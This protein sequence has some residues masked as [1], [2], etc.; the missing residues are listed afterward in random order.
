MKHV[1]SLILTLI[2]FPSITTAA[3]RLVLQTGHFAPVTTIAF[4]PDGSALASAGEDA[5]VRLWDVRTRELRDILGRHADQV[6]R[7]AF[8]PKGDVLAAVTAG[9][10]VFL[11]NW[12]TGEKLRDVPAHQGPAYAAAFSPDGKVLATGGK[13]GAIHLWD[14]RK[15]T[16]R[17]APKLPAAISKAGI[18]ALAFSPDGKKLAVGFSRAWVSSDDDVYDYEGKKVGAGTIALIDTQTNRV[19][20][21]LRTGRGEQIN[22]LVYSPDGRQLLTALGNRRAEI[23]PLAESAPPKILQSHVLQVTGAAF[24]PD[25]KTVITGSDDA[26]V[27]IWDAV[28]GKGRN[29]FTV[30]QGQGYCVAISPDGK[31]LATG[32]DDKDVRLWEIAGGKVQTVWRGDMN[33][34][35]GLVLPSDSPTAVASY[36]S[37]LAIAAN[38]DDHPELSAIRQWDLR[39]GKLMQVIAIPDYMPELQATTRDGRYLYGSTLDKWDLLRVA[40]AQDIPKRGNDGAHMPYESLALSPDETRLAML[41]HDVTLSVRSIDDGKVM[42]KVPGADDLSTDDLVVKFSPDGKTLSCLLDRRVATSGKAPASTSPIKNHLEIYNTA[43]GQL[44]FAH[45]LQA[46]RALAIA[47]SPD[48]EAVAVGDREGTLRLFGTEYPHNSKTIRVTN[49]EIND[50]DYSPDGRTISC[51]ADDGKIHIIE[52]ATGKELRAL[53]GHEMWTTNVRYLAGGKTIISGGTDMTLRLWRVSDGQLLVTLQILPASKYKELSRNW[54]AYTPTGYYTG[55]PN[56][57]KW[58]RWR[59]GKQLLPAE[60]FQQKYRRPDLISRTLAQL[61]K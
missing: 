27:K 31:T 13:D 9:G 10:R 43:S 12:R 26:T 1:L 22:S 2:V 3:P 24:T 52:V 14:T 23:W 40:R 59:I 51:A 45:P 11:W 35:D 44:L 34:V 55:S 50:L 7:I 4:A 6:C 8:A 61:R 19:E 5:T 48:S 20:R 38:E 60:K 30:N 41:E 15:A 39:T 57:E 42:W 36:R 32:S 49:R 16:R 56:C 54:I 33:H 21:H 29:T 58:I 47:Y 46:W 17:S 25:G 28:S 18:S 37:W 53:V